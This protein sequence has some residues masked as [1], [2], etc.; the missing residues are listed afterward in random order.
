[1]TPP[2]AGIGLNILRNEK[3]NKE[4]EKKEKVIKRKMAVQEVRKI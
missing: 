2:P 3:G 4:I 1:M